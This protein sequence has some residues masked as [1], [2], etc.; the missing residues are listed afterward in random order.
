MY[1]PLQLFA[2]E[3]FTTALGMPFEVGKT[4]LQIEYRPRKRFQPPEEVTEV[5]QEKD[6]GAE[7][8][9]VHCST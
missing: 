3:Y 9:E 1:G 7:D 8:D 2:T 6:W 5:A 4:L